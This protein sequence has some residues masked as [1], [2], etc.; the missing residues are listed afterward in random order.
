MAVSKSAQEQ[1]IIDALEKA[2]PA[3]AI[4]IVD[5]SVE[6]AKTAPIVCIRIDHADEDAEPITLDEVTAQGGWINE[7]V[8]EL[9]PFPGAYTLEISSPGMSRPLRR[10]HDF[11]RFAGETVRSSWTGLKAESAG[12]ASS[13]ASRMA[14]SRSIPTKGSS[15]SRSMRSPSA[16]SS[17]ISI[18]LERSVAAR[19]RPPRRNEIWHLK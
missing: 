15:A 9:D 4:D 18:L 12:R 7:V 14:Q 8:D 17:P 3:H 19:T 5:V 16:R 13:R 1:D 6:G 11:E 2:A 10:P